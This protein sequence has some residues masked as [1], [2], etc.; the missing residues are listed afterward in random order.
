MP[1]VGE[2]KTSSVFESVEPETLFTTLR[3][4]FDD[5]LMVFPR[6]GPLI[7]RA[8]YRLHEVFLGFAFQL[9]TP[10][11]LLQPEEEELL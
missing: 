3:H 2:G 8:I 4:K 1:V 6:C 5:A 7:V 9:S 11:P 10:P